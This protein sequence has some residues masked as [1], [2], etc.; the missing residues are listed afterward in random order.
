MKIAILGAA[1]H[2]V[3]YALTEIAQHTELELVGICEP[4]PQ[5]RERFLGDVDAPY[6]A[7][8]QQLLSAQHVDAALVAGV[9]SERGSAT[10]TALRGGAH[11]LADKPLC[12]DLDQLAAIRRAVADA[13]RHVSVVFEKRFHPATRALQRLVDNGVLGDLALIASTGPHKLDQPH[14]PSWFVDP[15]TYGGIAA[16]LPV[17]DIDLTLNLIGA[18]QTPPLHGTVT[19]HVGN[20]R[21]EEHP[22]FDDH[23]ALLMRAGTVPATIEAT[24]MQPSA[25]D[26]HGHY[27]MRVTGSQGTAELDWAYNRLTV[28]THDHR[29]WEEPLGS[30]ERPAR[31]FFDAVLAGRVPEITTDA[32]LRATE[33]ALKAQLSAQQY[34]QPQSF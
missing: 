32:S 6:Y 14:R 13:G 2:H 12:T 16:D 3:N 5:M 9:Y 31:Y 20:S 25:A 23:V 1:H 7:T 34:G 18:Q 11:V 29:T 15:S 33:I 26:V 30:P 19:A 22:G 24:W 28:T 8:V 27:R 4:D 17:H 10:V 21:P